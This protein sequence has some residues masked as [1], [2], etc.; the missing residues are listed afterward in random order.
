MRIEKLELQNWRN[1]RK[2]TVEFQPRTFIIGP[3]AS[4]KSNLLDALRFLRDIAAEDGGLQRAVK[5]RGGFGAIRTLFAHGPDSSVEL[6]LAARVGGEHWVYGLNL[7]KDEDDRAVVLAEVLRR[8]SEHLIDRDTANETVESQRQTRLQQALEGPEKEP[9]LRGLRSIRYA[10]L[11]PELLRTTRLHGDLD[12]EDYGSRFLERVFLTPKAERTSRLKVVNQALKGLLPY[13]DKL[14]VDRGE[15]GGYHLKLKVKHWRSRAAAQNE[16]SLSDGT[17]RVIA[18]LW[19]ILDG[20]GPLLLEEPE[21]SLHAAAVA[22]LPSLFS[23]ANDRGRQI[24][25]ST[26]AFS[27][28]REV[29][30]A[31]EELV[32]IRA[33]TAKKAEASTVVMGSKVKSI[34]DHLKHQAPLEPVLEAET[35]PPAPE[36]LLSAGT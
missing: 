26:H 21:L 5:R 27:M 35:L 34:T 23:L 17:L 6:G 32:L 36:K 25:V 9:F 1:F 16:A 33:A 4:G 30:F 2:A 7:Q 20:A 12:L 24:I 11:A 8:G 14:E 10:H 13:F 29:G 15:L 19:E 3:N 22:K 31:A 28:F 18:L